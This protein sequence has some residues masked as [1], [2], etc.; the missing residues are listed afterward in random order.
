MG[1]R[2]WAGAVLAGWVVLGACGP[3]STPVV[4]GGT[5]DPLPETP[6]GGSNPTPDGGSPPSDAGVAFGTPGPWPIANVLYRAAD[7]LLESP[8]IGLTTD[9]SQ[10]R[11]V[12]TRSALYLLRPGQTRFVRFAGAQGLHLAD[13]PVSYCDNNFPGPGV[14]GESAA[15]RCPVYGAA[16]ERGITEI[17]G[18]GPDEVFVGYAGNDEGSGDWCDP[19]R[20]SGK[21]DRVRLQADGSIVVDRFDLVSNG[22]GAMYWHNRTIHRMAFDHFTHK[23]ELY[24]GANHGVTLLRPDRFRRPAQGEWFD[25]VN[26]EYMGDHLHPRVCNGRACD[27]NSESNQLMGD[28]RGLALSPD[29]DLWVAGKWTAGKVR[30]TADLRAW[31]SRPGDKTFAVSFGDPYPTADNGNGYRNQPVFAVEAE[32]DPVYLTAVAVA[33]DGRVWFASGPNTTRGEPLPDGGVRPVID[34]GLAAWTGR[35]FQYVDPVSDLGLPD[36]SIRDLVALP[37]GRLVLALSSSGVWVWNPA[38]GEKKP[39]TAG[40][41]LPDERALRLQVDTMVNPPALHVSTSTGAAVIRV[42][43]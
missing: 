10:N 31:Y 5:V 33:A 1:I 34:Y 21:L 15:P 23:H 27:P 39:L 35:S 14:C 2:G 19:N 30:W 11:W 12:A 4:I 16:S 7:G 42:L 6:D 8:V 38:T 22:H 32:G 13:N 26:Q 36:R 28:W 25:S 24:V 17:V 29:G 3:T 43:P 40:A 41:Y 18:G 37:D 20:H 9:E